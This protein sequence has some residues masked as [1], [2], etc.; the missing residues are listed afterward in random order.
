MGVDGAFAMLLALFFFLFAPV[1]NLPGLEH[2]SEGTLWLLSGHPSMFRPPSFQFFEVFG[3][4]KV[5]RAYSIGTGF[6]LGR[7]AFMMKQA[8]LEM[9]VGYLTRMPRSTSNL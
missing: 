5:A 6:D 7:H 2:L 4:G 1:G 8:P 3:V 9:Q